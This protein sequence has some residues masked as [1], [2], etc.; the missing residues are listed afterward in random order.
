MGITHLI[1]SLSV[2]IM[3]IS[4]H[5]VTGRMMHPFILLFNIFWVSFVYQTWYQTLGIPRDLDQVPIFKELP[6]IPRE[7]AIYWEGKNLGLLET[8]LN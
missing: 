5:Q 2:T 4:T 8:S 3:K 1:L 7:I 6:V